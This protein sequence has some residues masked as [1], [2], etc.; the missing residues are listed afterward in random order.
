MGTSWM[1]LQYLPTLARKNLGVPA[2]STKATAAAEKRRLCLSGESVNMQQFLKNS[3]E[4]KIAFV[5]A[6]CL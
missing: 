5:I 3:P 6:M 2:T 4:L 1:T